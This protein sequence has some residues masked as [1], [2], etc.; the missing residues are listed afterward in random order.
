M[1]GESIVYLCVIFHMRL[2]YG[3]S[4]K[5]QSARKM[6]F[7]YGDASPVL[8]MHLHCFV[9]SLKASWLVVIHSK[10]VQGNVD[11]KKA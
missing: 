4:L 3:R 10:S 1:I 8:M 7:A 9:A 2:S 11:S 5:M 6:I